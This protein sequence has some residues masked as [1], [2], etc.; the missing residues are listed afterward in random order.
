MWEYDA[1]I[2]K[3]FVFSFFLYM[4][5]TGLPVRVEAAVLEAHF[6]QS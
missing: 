4:Y 1:A 6:K 5:L 3:V 2:K